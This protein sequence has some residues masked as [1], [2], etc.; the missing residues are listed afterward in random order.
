MPQPPL[1]QLAPVPPSASVP[2]SLRPTSIRLEGK[3]QFVPQKDQI[4][5]S[6]PVDMS[7]ANAV[8]AFSL[9]PSGVV[10]YSVPV[11]AMRP[12]AGWKPSSPLP[13]ECSTVSLPVLGSSENSVP[14]PGGLFWHGLTPPKDV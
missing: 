5:V 4:T 2:Y 11:T 3:S 8:P 13:N 12:V 6:A 9:P 7:N 14:Q 1:P 10:P